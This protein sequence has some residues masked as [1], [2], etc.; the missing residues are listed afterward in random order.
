MQL[1]RPTAVCTLV[2]LAACAGL[3]FAAGKNVKGLVGGGS[4]PIKLADGSYVGEIRMFATDNGPIA[5]WLEC[6]G[7]VLNDSG[8]YVQLFNV[9]GNRFGGGGPNTFKLPDLRGVFPRG[10]NHGKDS[11][12][13]GFL[14]PEAPTRTVFKGGP[15]YSGDPLKNDQV[16]TYQQDAVQ[17]HQHTDAGHNHWMGDN[18][19]YREHVGGGGGYGAW[20]VPDGASNPPTTKLGYA[21]IGGPVGARVASETRASN[22]AVM[23]YIRYQ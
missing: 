12:Q 5:G 9:I 8:P 16:G 1:R 10:W 3:G 4:A 2:L 11:T 7:R 13:E 6:D 15:D 19:W 17:S 20:S 21:S 22:V 14:D 23:F 18:V